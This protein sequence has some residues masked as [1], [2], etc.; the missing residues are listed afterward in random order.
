MVEQILEDAS[1]A[2]RIRYVSLRY[3][4]ASGGHPDG[5][6][7]EDHYPE[8]HLIP[9]VLKSILSEDPDKAVTLFGTDYDTPDGTCIRDYIHVMDLAAAHLLALDYLKNGGRSDVFNLGSGQGSSVL[10]VVRTAEKVTGRPIPVTKAPRRSG[11]PPIL[12]ASSKKIIQEL[13]WKSEYPELETII[14]TAWKWHTAHP[15]GYR[16]E[17]NLSEPER[18]VNEVKR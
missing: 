5:N 17:L 9:K 1:R 7:G 3:F 4:N 14:E 12:V 8:T 13:G 10:E 16:K 2:S 18:P 15:C 11:D 6:M